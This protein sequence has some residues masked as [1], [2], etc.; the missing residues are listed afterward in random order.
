MIKIAICNY[1]W[2]INCLRNASKS[3]IYRK[4]AKKSTNK[5]NFRVNVGKKVN[6]FEKKFKKSIFFFKIAQKCGIHAWNAIK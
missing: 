2:L 4:N 3:Q 6:K 5:S 1:H